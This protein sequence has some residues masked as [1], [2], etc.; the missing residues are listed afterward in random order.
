MYRHTRRLAAGLL[1]IALPACGADGP[2]DAADGSGYYFSARID[3][4][5][6]SADPA[7]ISIAG[8]SAGTP[9]M[10]SFQ[11]SALSGGARSITMHLARIPGVG[12]YPL[13]MN[14]GTGTG[15]IATYVVGSRSWNTGLSGAAGTVTISEISES[16]VTGTFEFDAAPLD[17]GGGS[18]AVREGRFRVPRSPGFTA[19]TAD[20]LGNRMSGTIDGSPWNAA[21]VVTAGGPESLAAVTAS[22][23]RYT[24]TLAFGPV[25]GPGSGP[26]APGV[27]VRRVSV[28]RVGSAGG[29]GGTSLDVGTLTIRTLSATRVSGTFSASL[30][31]LAGASGTL[32]IAD[33]EFDVRRAR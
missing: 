27:P 21:T 7:M 5:P 26:L 33:M 18:I 13:G 29:W 16:D 12:T 23:D 4:D 2:T 25:S 8:A 32:Q 9:G 20:E 1:L 10:L 17:G 22:N 14:I 28:H 31:P 30:A 19:A 11:G 24:V 3:G 6:W 15:G